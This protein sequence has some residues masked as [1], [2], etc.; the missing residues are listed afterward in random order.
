LLRQAAELPA[1]QRLKF[2]VLVD[3]S[4]NPVEFPVLI[5]SRDEFPQVVI[6][7]GE[8][9]WILVYAFFLALASL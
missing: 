3:L 2:S 5:Q 9:H 8:I 4:M 1:H 7:F 6:G